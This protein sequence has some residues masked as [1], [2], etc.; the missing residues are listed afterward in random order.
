MYRFSNNTLICKKT[1]LHN[2]KN[3]NSVGLT[4]NKRYKII[5]SHEEHLDNDLFGKIDEYVYGI[6]DDFGNVWELY[7]NNAKLGNP[8]NYRPI[9][10][11]RHLLDDLFYTTEEYRELQ[12]E[13][14]I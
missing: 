8:Y 9:S 14:L 4:R 1:V 12:L 6:K 10:I 11:K 2:H 5:N 7:Y 13:K 3:V